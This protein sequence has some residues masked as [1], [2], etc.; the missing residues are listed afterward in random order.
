MPPHGKTVHLDTF[1]ATDR[2]DTWWV[3]PVVTVVV[4]GG[5]VVYATLRAWMNRHY[6]VGALLSPM[7]SP[8]LGHWT[9]LPQWLSPAFLILWAPAGFRLTCYYYRKAY[10]RAFTLHPPACAVTESGDR[11]Y[12]GET[13]FP[14][15]LQNAHRYFLYFAILF[16]I[17]LWWDAIKAF[18]VD[19]HFAVTVGT[20]VLTANAF[21][22][23]GYT[24]SCHSFRHLVGGKLDFFS[25]TGGSRARHELWKGC[26]ALNE[27]HMQ[28][29]WTSLVVVAFADFYVWMVASGHW[30]DFQIV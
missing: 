10:Y 8:N 22:L 20:L 12:Q 28:W 2:R 23:T 9:P 30:T 24:L 17:F 15:V 16:P 27:K 7:Y 5:F 14:L 6:E 3:G 29:A 26:T 21:L 25:R 4:L 1:L 19:G 18:S 11:G 13:G